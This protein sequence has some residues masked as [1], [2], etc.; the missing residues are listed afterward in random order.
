M[1]AARAMIPQASLQHGKWSGVAYVIHNC[2]YLVWSLSVTTT[3][4]PIKS[5]MQNWSS[6]YRNERR[7]PASVVVE[8]NRRLPYISPTVA[9]PPDKS[10]H[11]CTCTRNSFSGSN[12]SMTPSTT[13]CVVSAVGAVNRTTPLAVQPLPCSTIDTAARPA[14]IHS[15]IRSWACRVGNTNT[16]HQSL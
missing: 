3:D 4:L 13:T 12:P 6:E 16:D 5:E 2:E 11:S 7:P 14:S 10:P 9:H 1:P 15:Y 8:P